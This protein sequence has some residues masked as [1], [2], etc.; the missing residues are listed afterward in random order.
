MFVACITD[1]VILGSTSYTA[2]MHPCICDATCNDCTMKHA[3]AVP[4]GSTS[5]TPSMKGSSEV[6]VVQHNRV[7]AVWLE[8]PLEVVDSVTG[9]GSR[10]TH[11]A[12]VKTAV[13]PSR[14]MPVTMIARPPVAEAD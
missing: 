9:T 14:V 11:H 4:R 7:E 6:A 5:F 13:H 1:E 10:A 12:D 3:V 2:M 8:G